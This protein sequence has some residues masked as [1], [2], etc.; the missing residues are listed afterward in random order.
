MTGYNWKTYNNKNL[1]L[2]K[3]LI[4]YN[5]NNKF[6]FIESGIYNQVRDIFCLSL[7]IKKKGEIKVL[8]F[9]SNIMSLSNIKNKIS[10]NKYK[11]FIYDPFSDNNKIIKDPFKIHILKDKN[12]IKK[13]NFDI[14]N[15]GSSIQYLNNL[16][17]LNK[18]INFDK[19]LKIIITHT[20]LTLKKEFITK[21]ANHRNL[22]Q[23]VFNYKKLLNFFKK[24][25]YYLIFK[26]RN[27]SKYASSLKNKDS[28]YSLN[29]VLEKNV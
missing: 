14:I 22:Q 3:K 12:D 8:D 27:N 21:Q 2:S 15:F 7:L 9:G 24:K 29:L 20:P 19:T 5:K 6:N 28:T 1:K 25:G 16:S 10:T 26:S 17:E 23:M 18:V 11:F 13:E 4:F